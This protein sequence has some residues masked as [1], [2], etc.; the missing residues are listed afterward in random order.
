MGCTNNSHIIV[1]PPPPRVTRLAPVV[2]GD[3]GP[4]LRLFVP[5]VPGN[6]WFPGDFRNRVWVRIGPLKIGR[7]R[8]QIRPEIKSRSWKILLV[9]SSRLPENCP[10]RGLN[11]A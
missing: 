10:K 2:W 7:F 11:S 9:P 6:T 4:T 1:L 8:D 3:P 5:T